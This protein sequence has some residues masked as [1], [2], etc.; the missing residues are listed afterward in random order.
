MR[1]CPGC[2]DVGV[3]RFAEKIDNTKLTADSFSSRK[4]PELLHHE[5]LECVN[6]KSLFVRSVPSQNQLGQKYEAATFISQVESASAA[7]TYLRLVEKLNVLPESNVLDLGCAD[8]AFLLEL[9]R[10]GV[11]NLAGVEPSV[12]SIAAADEA[13]RHLIVQGGPEALPAD[14]TYRL[15]TCFQTI[16]HVA[17]PVE[18]VGSIRERV[19]DGGYFAIACHNRKSIVNK[20][21]GEKS[22]IFDIEHMQLFTPLGIR[23]LFERSGFSGVHVKS[24]ANSYPLF[25]WISLAPVP[26]I[27]KDFVDKRRHWKLFGT[28]ITLPVGN[29]LVVGQIRL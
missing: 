21:L 7:R 12:E 2:G 18:F 9:H 19:S 27:I 4:R 29:L 23:T 3:V 20:L 17:D 16:E 22:P 28:S 15:V 11:S 10:H 5:Y 24:Y 6:C 26:R 25:Y 8:G 14:T 13:V 1:A